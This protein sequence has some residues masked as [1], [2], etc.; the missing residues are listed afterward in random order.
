M[1]FQS[2]ILHGHILCLILYTQETLL[3]KSAPNIFRVLF[4]SSGTAHVANVRQLS[5]RG[6]RKSI[7]E[8]RDGRRLVLSESVNIS[9]NDVYEYLHL[10]VDE[11]INTG[12][13]LARARVST[14]LKADH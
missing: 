1:Y 2:T 11:I 7:P 12:S 9:Q 3:W 5:S 6:L 4:I 10:C 13:S 8:I 14:A